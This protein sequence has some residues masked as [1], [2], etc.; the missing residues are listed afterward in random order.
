MSNTISLTYLP[1][2]YKAYPFSHTQR[3]IGGRLTNID[4]FYTCCGEKLIKDAD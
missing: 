1:K 2:K 4:T 3:I